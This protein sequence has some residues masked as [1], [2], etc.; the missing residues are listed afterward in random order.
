MGNVNRITPA[1]AEKPLFTAATRRRIPSYSIFLQPSRY[2]F[3]SY[4][5]SPRI[6]ATVRSHAGTLKQF[7]AFS[8][9]LC[10][11]PK[12]CISSSL[13]FPPDR[14][15]FP[16]SATAA[17]SSSASAALP[18]PVNTGVNTQIPSTAPKDM[19]KLTSPSRSGSCKTSNTA[20]SPMP[21]SMSYVLPTNIPSICNRYIPMARL[22]DT[23]IPTITPY[24]S[25]ITVPP[26]A[27]TLTDAPSFLNSR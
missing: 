9:L 23:F 14:S 6:S 12:P 16:K 25:N 10:S 3:L 1:L 22:A 19:K 17:T 20:S 21:V 24:R 5:E 13:L 27:A 7:H 4:A 8:R 11:I 2:L 18:L 15:F 26:T